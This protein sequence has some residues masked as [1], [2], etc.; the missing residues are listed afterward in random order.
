VLLSRQSHGAAGFKLRGSAVR[1]FTPSNPEPQDEAWYVFLT[2]PANNH[3]VAWTKVRARA[4]GARRGR[5]RLPAARRGRGLLGPPA[6]VA[7][8]GSP[9]AFSGWMV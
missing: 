5:H 4:A 9:R 2:D 1:A 8:G 3:V 7:F 6:A